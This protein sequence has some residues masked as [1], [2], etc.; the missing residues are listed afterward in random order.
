M[1]V[2]DVVRATL[3][4]VL[5]WV[6]RTSARPSGLVLVYHRVGASAGDP[7]LQ[8]DPGV[9]G[10]ELGRQLR[11]LRRHYRVVPA[12]EIVA[13]AGERRRGRRFPVAIT[14]DDD[15]ASH[16]H[17]ALPALLKEGLQATFFLCGASLEEPH[18]FWWED[19]Q[20]AVDGRLVAPARLPHVSEPDLLAALDRSPRAI[21]RVASAIERLEPAQRDEVAHAL[22]QAAGPPPE[23]AGARADD[24]RALVDA[25]LEVGFHTL[26]HDALPALSDTALEQALHDGREQLAAAAGRPLAL[27]GYPHGKADARVAEAARQAGFALG[28]TTSAGLAGPATDPLLI[29]R[30]VPASSASAFALQVA[31]AFA[32]RS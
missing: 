14:F 7:E 23:D 32:G 27:I 6:A 21:R 5:R 25:G 11:H 12:A 24:V 31:R 22:R 4:S 20:S 19:L 13:Q 16:A 30:V 2:R 1:S 26:R 28:F 3:A 15:L 29:P 17:E 9:T 18:T 8:I 10:P